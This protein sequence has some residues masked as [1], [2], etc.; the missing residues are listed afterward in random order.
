MILSLSTGFLFKN[1]NPSYSYRN[2]MGIKV[3]SWDV[4]IKNLA[5]CIL[6]KLDDVD[7]SKDKPESETDKETDNITKEKAKNS[8]A[9]R[10]WGIINLMKDD[11]HPQCSI[12]GNK[13]CMNKAT[14]IY[15]SEGSVIGVCTRHKKLHQ[16]VDTKEENHF[17]KHE[18]RSNC[19]YSEKCDKPGFYK[20]KNGDC[21]CSTH[22]KSF[23]SRLM[24]DNKLKKIKNK[25][26]NE[27]SP[28][29]LNEKLCRELDKMPE[30]L[31]V[32]EVVIENQPR[33]MNPIM[34]RIASCLSTYFVIRGRIDSGKVVGG[35]EGNKINVRNISPTNKLKIDSIHVK[36]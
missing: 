13:D 3:C 25:K 21:Y 2:K 24:T 5:Y 16:P 18:E 31:D 4:G 12:P 15:T 6:E 17:T 20:H 11:D 29:V 19:V 36:K 23:V 33:L 7:K 22:R 34:G 26:Y 32:D 8:F 10:G 1:K 27:I 35:R 28:Q 14:Y 9:I 30:L